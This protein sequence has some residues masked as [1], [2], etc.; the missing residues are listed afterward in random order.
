MKITPHLT[1]IKGQGHSSPR[2]VGKTAPALNN[3]NE[4]G[5]RGDIVDVVSLE[6]RRA[7]TDIPRSQEEL[8]RLLQEVQTGIKRMNRDEIK[9]LHRLEGL[10]HVFSKQ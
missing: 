4:A 1:I 9:K 8:D 5:A 3:N 10:V 2:G 7:L 6:N